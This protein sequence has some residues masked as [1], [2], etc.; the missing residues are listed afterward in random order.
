[1]CG[2]ATFGQPH[3]FLLIGYFGVPPICRGSFI[4][5]SNSISEKRMCFH[6]LRKIGVSLRAGPLLALSFAEMAPGKR[7]AS[8]MNNSVNATEVRI[9]L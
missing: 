7:P 2:I 3:P 4:P 1:M 9:W 5:D 8:Y 6:C